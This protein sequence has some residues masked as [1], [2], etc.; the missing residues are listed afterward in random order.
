MVTSEVV[1]YAMAVTV[2]ELVW[3]ETEM[4]AKGV[5]RLATT[6]RNDTQVG[7]IDSES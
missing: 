1:V 2:I 7:S 3:R 5:P 6:D 4:E